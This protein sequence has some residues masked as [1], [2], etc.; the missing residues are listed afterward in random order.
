MGRI[1]FIDGK[2]LPAN[3][4]KV[5]IFDRG[6][7]FA[8]GV[9]EVTAVIR[10]CL[11]DNAEHMAR[12]FRSMQA[13]GMPALS[14]TPE[15]IQQAQQLLVERNH[16]KEGTVYLQVTRGVA[17]RS[18]TFP[19]NPRLT[20]VMF[21]QAQDIIDA[22][23]AARGMSVITMPDMRWKRRDIKT[24]GLL[25]ASMARQAA[26]RAGAEDAWLV[27]NGYVTEGTSSNTYILTRD[28]V[29]KTQP[30]GHQILSGITRRAIHG[31][32]EQYGIRIEYMPF[33]VEEAMQAREAFI[34]SA[35]T[36][37]TPVVRLDG[38][39]VGAGCPGPFVQRLRQLYIAAALD[40]A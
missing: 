28:G 34:T 26:L 3:E 8:D 40:S 4:G 17:E 25:A 35:S 1:V 33:T 31:L 6:F 14:M 7:L 18:F 21:T 16:L 2:Y 27:E 37:V 11:V 12:L 39:P 38:Q 32:S 9:Y 19:E 5:S 20:V 36:L 10:G 29:V 22:P 23:L 13:L 24:T 30:E 15:A